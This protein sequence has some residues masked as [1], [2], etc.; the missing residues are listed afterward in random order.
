[1][2]HPG[3]LEHRG[4]GRLGCQC[5]CRGRR[6]RRRPSR[7]HGHGQQP[8]LAQGQ[9]G[10]RLHDSQLRSHRQRGHTAHG[11]LLSR[12]QRLVRHASLGQHGLVA[13]AAFARHQGKVRAW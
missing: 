1:M 2:R 13:R 5:H 3:E 9:A 12:Q 7:R 6:R 8:L 4:R 10:H 11:E